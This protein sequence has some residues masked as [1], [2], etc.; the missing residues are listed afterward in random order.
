MQWLQAQTCKRAEQESAINLHYFRLVARSLEELSF[1]ALFGRGRVY[2]LYKHFGGF[3]TGLHLIRKQKYKV[4]R[5]TIP[6][7]KGLRYLTWP[8]WNITGDSSRS[9]PFNPIER[10]T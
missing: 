1:G 3:Q 5:D 9:N 8:N 6:P 10:I 2:V 7:M 4:H